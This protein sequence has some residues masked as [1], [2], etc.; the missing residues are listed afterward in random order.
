[1]V[2]DMSQHEQ[3]FNN[4][5]N[6]VDVANA[7]VQISRVPESDAAVV[8]RFEPAVRRF[9]R[10]RTRT[11]EDADDAVQDTFMRFL[12][13]SEQKIHNKEA[14]LITAASRAC[15]D[16]SRRHRRDDEHV[17]LSA[18]R[19]WCLASDQTAEDIVD[20]HAD[21]PE[22]V[23]VEHLTIAALFRRMRPRERVVIAHLYLMG[24][25]STQ[26]ANYL[27]VTP[28]NLFVIASRARRHARAIL[29]D[30]ERT[31]TQ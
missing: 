3:P 23:A 2:P 12:R 10:S 11:P 19:D 17:S 21:K 8:L 9:C 27:G 5:T 7:T 22:Q 14:W 16:I 28:E 25:T 13:R 24:A 29:V 30:M 31:S 4:F 15:A 18:K 6:S 26:V 20:T 1:M